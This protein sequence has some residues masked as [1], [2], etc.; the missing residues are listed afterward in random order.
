[1]RPTTV[2][3]FSA[4]ALSACDPGTY[5]GPAPA[6]MG[7]GG[8]G[9]AS[10]GGGAG[11]PGSGGGAAGRAGGSSGGAA[12]GAA[13]AAGGT[14]GGVAGGAAGGA[15]GTAGGAA[16]QPGSS[17]LAGEI[18]GN[19]MFCG[20]TDLTG[21]AII[22]A[23][24]TVTLCD[25][26]VVRAAAMSSLT[27]KGTL[28]V[29]PGAMGARLGDAGWKGLVVDGG[30]L[31]GRLTIVGA[32][33]GLSTTTGTATLSDLSMQMVRSP[34]DLGVGSTVTVTRGNIVATGG[35]A[36]VKG[37]LT[38]DHV[39]WN[40]GGSAG[41]SLS[42][43]T[44]E[45]HAVDSRFS[46]G[47]SS[48]FFV[49]NQA[50]TLHIEYSEISA[51]HCGLHIN[52]IGTLD[53]HHNIITG[54]SL[55]FMIGGGVGPGRRVVTQNNIIANTEAG[56]E[57]IRD[58]ELIDMR[59]NYFAMNAQDVLMST[60]QGLDVGGRLAAAVADAGPRP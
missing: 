39:T 12:G 1:M 57:Q 19:Q 14:A 8:S 49:T 46:V 7:T 10:A 6:G 25:G 24:A 45:I 20:T 33:K 5:T 50:G 56:I 18:T 44:A 22:A 53:L 38:L 60:L 55:G 51:T 40:A 21:D 42:D 9:A 31:Q 29:A 35:G 11:S 28:T 15:A 37:K 13:G 26:A 32:D 23:G 34:F 43:A 17:G 36:T 30:T 3:L 16:G 27:I 4:L 48:D 2:A 52:T 47:A 41:V 54:N 58:S 59:G